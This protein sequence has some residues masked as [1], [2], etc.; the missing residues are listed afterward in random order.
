MSSWYS[1]HTSVKNSVE[2]Q[3]TR[4]RYSVDVRYRFAVKNAKNE[5]LIE[6]KKSFFFIYYV[7]IHAYKL[8][9]TGCQVFLDKSAAVK[10]AS[11]FVNNRTQ[12]QRK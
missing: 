5:N 9:T 1:F 10:L 4:K 12:T 7:F 2:I 8:Y 3:P 11:R 6:L